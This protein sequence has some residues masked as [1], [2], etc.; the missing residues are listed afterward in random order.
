MSTDL[1]L[2]IAM[3]ALRE[4]SN[5]NDMKIANEKAK[6]CWTMTGHVETVVNFLCG[7]IKLAEKAL[8]EIEDLK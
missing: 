8:K 5:E 1:K 2:H 6:S 4:I 7:K 3:K